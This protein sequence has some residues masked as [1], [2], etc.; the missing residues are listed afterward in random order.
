LPESLRKAYRVGVAEILA[1]LGG[2]RYHHLTELSLVDGLY[3]GLSGG[4]Y[5]LLPDAFFIGDQNFRHEAL[6]KVFSNAGIGNAASWLASNSELQCFL[7]DVRGGSG[8][9]ESELRSMVQ[10]RNIAAHEAQIEDIVGPE[11]F[12]KHADFVTCL[13]KA[14]HALVCHN[15][16]SLRLAM[17]TAADI[18]T[19]VQRFRD[20]VIGAECPV[21][22]L[23]PGDELYVVRPNACFRTIIESIQ[24][25]GTTHERVSNLGSVKVG[26]KLTQGAKKDSRL[27]RLEAPARLNEPPAVEPIASPLPINPDGPTDLAVPSN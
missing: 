19:V 8:T 21:A 10:Y 22:T 5:M 3:S 2:D 24:I 13:C 6:C 11:E 9:C 25:E 20:N 26:L 23:A 16:I 1:K 4:G 18:G 7:R 14:V 12:S 15:I 17:G 27:I